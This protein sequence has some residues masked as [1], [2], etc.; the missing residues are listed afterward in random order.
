MRI[1]V[2]RNA[3]KDLSGLGLRS[4]LGGCCVKVRLGVAVVLRSGLGG[5]CVNVRLGVAVVLMS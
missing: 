5:C 4:G 2:T 1:V 3:R